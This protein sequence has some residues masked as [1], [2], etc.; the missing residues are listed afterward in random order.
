MI[1][2]LLNL[3]FMK[4]D[5]FLLSI[6]KSIDQ[7]GSAFSYVLSLLVYRQSPGKNQRQTCNIYNKSNDGFL[8]SGK[9]TKALSDSAIFTDRK[10]LSI[11]QWF[12]KM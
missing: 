3:I 2:A 1:D 9:L 7:C 5:I 4:L 6:K 8:R 10:N 11:D 12:S